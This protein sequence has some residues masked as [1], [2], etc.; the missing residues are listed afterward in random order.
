MLEKMVKYFANRHLL[1]NFIYIG[2]IIAGLF[3]WGEM[4]KEEM[5]NI[6]F[7]WVNVS[8]SYSGASPE[9]VEYFI[10]KE[11]EDKLSG[12]DG[13]DTITSVSSFGSSSISVSLEP[14]RPDRSEI[15]NEI[16][17][18][19]A[20]ARLPDDVIDDPRVRE[21]KSTQMSIIDVGL[22]FKDVHLLNEEQRKTLQSYALA[23]EDR[24]LNLK[25]ISGS[26]RRG[27][28]SPEIRIEVI[29]EKI[30]KYNISVSKIA[31]ITAAN[32]ALYPAGSLE[33][34][35]ESRVTLN[36]ELN[37]EEKLSRV[38]VQGGFEGQKVYLNDIAEIKDT[39]EKN[40]R[41][42]KINGHEG[43]FIN[44]VKKS[45]AGILE[46]MD[47]LKKTVNN[48]KKNNLKDTGVEVVFLDD[49]SYDL[50]NRLSIIA[51]NGTIGLIFVIASLL[52]LLNRRTA[53]WVALGI[54]FT[55]CFTII[56]SYFLGF[57]VNNVTLAAVIIVMGMV[58]D[59]AIIVAENISR[60]RA[61]GVSFETAAV[62]GTTY[63][64]LPVTAAIITTC[65][66][67]TPL[68]HFTG[69]M[70]EM[71]KHTTPRSKMAGC[72]KGQI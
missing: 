18:A 6:T 65:V 1:T 20:D 51:S 53:L 23:L 59:D 30:R 50:K 29:P 33:D 4:K 2:V 26:N 16:R 7:D 28:V 64:L 21:F 17:T 54:P 48:F 63:V 72:R 38:I 66:A 24:I 34:I 13:I 9:Q 39:F 35:V 57:T 49:E 47:A 52:L 11:L 40:T 19:V 67:F 10:T 56:V 60:T 62:R 46:A 32:N 58:V 41:I 55:F 43:I 5:P 70:G 36:S 3:Y 27:Y 31:S 14:G 69:R 44:A 12:I 37:S 68:L 61:S 8:A 45:D 42:L 71:V 15:I 22:Y 25:E